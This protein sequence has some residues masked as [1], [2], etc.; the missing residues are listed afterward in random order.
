MGRRRSG[1]RQVI[2]RISSYSSF[3]DK[4]AGKGLTMQVEETQKFYTLKAIDGRRLW[5]HQIWKSTYLASKTVVGVNVSQESADQADFEANYKTAAEDKPPTQEMTRDGKLYVHSTP[6]PVG[7]TTYFTGVGDN[8]ADKASVGGGQKAMIDHQSGAGD[9]A[10]DIHLNMAANM[11]YLH[12]GFITWTSAV[13]DTVSLF[14]MA[15][16]STT[17]AGTNTNYTTLA[18]P[19]HPWDGKLIVPAAANGAID[20]TTPVLIGFY[21]NSNKDESATPPRYW[22]ATWNPATKV[23]DN[24]TA[25]PAGDGEFNMFTDEMTLFCFAREIILEGNNFM[26]WPFQTYDAQRLGDG[27]F[28]RLVPNTNGVDHAW[29]CMTTLV[30][31][32]ASTL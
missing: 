6:A 27:M 22:N 31:Y 5:V 24:I 21:P 26:P 12:S 10:V 2:R 3:R 25:A 30:M 19:G 11:T 1:D 16:G 7:A 29:K 20:V 13:Q 32:R 4:V 18:Y 15:Y 28:L 8:P 17:T 9:I 23:Y 14:V